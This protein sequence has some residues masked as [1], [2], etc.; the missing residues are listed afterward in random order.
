MSGESKVAAAPEAAKPAPAALPTAVP[1]FPLPGVV[2]LPGL[3]VHLHIFEDRYRRMIRD[4]PKDR[5]LF[6][7]AVPRGEADDPGA[8]AIEPVVCIGRATQIE[9]TENGRYN[10]VF[11]GLAR[12]R[13]GE[14]L[15]LTTPYRIG[16]VAWLDPREDR[17]PRH[18]AIKLEIYRSFLAYAAGKKDLLAKFQPLRDR[19]LALGRLVDVTSACLP[20]HIDVQKKLLSEL[21][22][23]RRA[24]VLL[25]LLDAAAGK[26]KKKTLN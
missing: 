16:Q 17:D 7:L 9:L 20:L 23:L 19:D 12:A 10:L 11:V 26:V 25:A 13:V 14:E 2:A 3:A 5:P 1:L 22:V 24:L 18:V 8:G 15:P 6:A 21:D 4:L